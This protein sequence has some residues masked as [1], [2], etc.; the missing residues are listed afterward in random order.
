MGQYAF[1]FDQSR[2]YSCHACSVAC[3]DWNGIEAGP[4]KWMSVYE[5][6]EGAF[7]DIRLRGL[8]F[9]CAHCDDPACVKA[10][11]VGAVTKEGE[12]G[13]VLVD[14]DACMGCR[15]C[16]EACPYGSPKFADDGSDTKMS[17]CTMCVDRLNEGHIPVCVASCP[18]RALDFGPVDEMTAKYGTSRWLDQMPEPVTSPNFI[19]K[20]AADRKRIV[21]YDAE[22]AVELMKKR[23]GLDDLF[24]SAQ[25]VTEVPREALRSPELRMKHESCETRLRS[26]H[27]FA[28]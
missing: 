23:E 4:E 10:C 15:A 26:T 25:D 18:L 19:V 11:T 27:N 12:Y 24:D 16:Y 9:P 1:Y 2:C 28:G 14:Q 17:K 8:A 13:A 5:W 6:E 21:S 20:A 7:P 22:K 3:K